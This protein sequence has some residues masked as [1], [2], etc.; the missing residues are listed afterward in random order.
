MID[1]EWS[2]SF[3]VELLRADSTGKVLGYKHL[4]KLL[5]SDAVLCHTIDGRLP[6]SRTLS[7]RPVS[8]LER[9]VMS[10]RAGS[11]PSNF[12]ADAACLLT[13]IVHAVEPVSLAT[14][15]SLTVVGQVSPVPRE[16][17]GRIR[18]RSRLL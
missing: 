12:V 3:Q 14:L 18:L 6:K 9:V 16:W 7:A 15:S 17:L 8:I 5:G 1:S 13:V 2:L 4:L 11:S 10:G